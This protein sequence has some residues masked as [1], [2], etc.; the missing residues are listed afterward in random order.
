[1]KS[2]LTGLMQAMGAHQATE[3]TEFDAKHRRFSYHVSELYRVKESMDLWM[4]TFDMFCSSSHMLGKVFKN[5]FSINTA[6]KTTNSPYLNVSTAFEEVLK[7][8]KDLVQP[9]IKEVFLNRCYKPLLA[10]LALV[11]PINEQIVARKTMLLDF[12]SFRAKLEKEIAAGR[13]SSHPSSIKNL[14]KLDESSKRLWEVQQNIYSLFDEFE[15]AKGIMLGAEFTSFLGCYYHNYF[16]TSDL[17]ERLLPSLPQVGSTLSLL[18]AKI[19]VFDE[20]KP[21]STTATVPANQISTTATALSSSSSS[22]SSS[23]FSILSKLGLRKVE[24]PPSNSEAALQS[25]LLPGSADSISE[26][27]LFTTVSDSNPLLLFPSARFIA[28]LEAEQSLNTVPPIVR[29][30][31]ILGGSYGGYGVIEPQPANDPSTGSKD[32]TR[33]THMYIAEELKAQLMNSSKKTE[34]RKGSLAVFYEDA[35]HTKS[36]EIDDLSPFYNFEYPITGEVALPNSDRSNSESTESNTTTERVPV[37]T[38]KRQLSPFRNQRISQRTTAESEESSRLT[39][40]RGYITDNSNRRYSGRLPHGPVSSTTTST[41]PVTTTAAAAAAASH[42]AMTDESDDQNADNESSKRSSR[43]LSMDL[44]RLSFGRQPPPK[45][46]KKRPPSEK[47]SSVSDPNNPTL[48]SVDSNS[49]VSVSVSTTVDEEE[50]STTVGTTV[51][52]LLDD[53]VDTVDGGYDKIL[54]HN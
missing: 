36:E 47:S 37:I 45:P 11:P 43:I 25:E 30:S 5:Y 28:R 51:K 12:D 14:N 29:R 27:E 3:D 52:I 46:E 41:T 16:C 2:N 19:R 40:P 13:D 35:Y 44:S 39:P 50:A 53:I 32:S 15:G 6:T 34:S 23:S 48:E 31:E 49:S 1:M 21:V 8:I 24:V 9:S 10:I 4:E 17:V 54:E 26:K 20:K 33:S 42:S 18:E 7:D 38:E 22:S